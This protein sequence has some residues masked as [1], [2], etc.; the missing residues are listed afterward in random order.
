MVKKNSQASPPYLLLANIGQLLTLRGG[1][2]RRGA[3]AAYRK[4]V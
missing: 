1:M 4:L 2:P 3:D